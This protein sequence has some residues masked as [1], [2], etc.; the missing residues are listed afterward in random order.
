MAKEIQ[1]KEELNCLLEA[2]IAELKAELQEGRK[3]LGIIASYLKK[4]A[5]KQPELHRKTLLNS[6]KGSAKI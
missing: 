3:D 4:K 5:G 2:D 1:K 6:T